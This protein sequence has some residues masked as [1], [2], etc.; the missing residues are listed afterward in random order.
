[1][2]T[3]QETQKKPAPQP[4]K[5]KRSP[6]TWKGREVTRAEYQDYR[7][8]AN[9]GNLRVPTGKYCKSCGRVEGRVHKSDCPDVCNLG[10]Y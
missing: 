3:N 8:H 4:E 1:M 6:R 10:E 9:G 5:V 7:K 2:A